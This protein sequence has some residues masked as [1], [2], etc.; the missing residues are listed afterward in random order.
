LTVTPPAEVRSTIAGS[1]SP[2]LFH[3]TAP[4]FDGRYD[5]FVCMALFVSA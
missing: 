3:R 2:E 5:D 4:A 1:I